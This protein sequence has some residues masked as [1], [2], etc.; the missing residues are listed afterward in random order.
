MLLI[1]PS[2]I[3]AYL[4][5]A[6]LLICKMD[7]GRCSPFALKEL[8]SPSVTSPVNNIKI[9]KHISHSKDYP[10]LPTAFIPLLFISSFI[11]SVR[12]RILLSLMLAYGRHWTGIAYGFF[13]RLLSLIMNTIMCVAGVRF[14]RYRSLKNCLN[15]GL[16][17]VNSLGIFSDET[18]F[19][20]K[21]CGMLACLMMFAIT[22]S[23]CAIFCASL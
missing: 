9:I 20:K 8:N 17:S 18:A 15:F 14:L 3:W 4:W 1:V 5:R 12:S 11:L 13:T 6:S 21:P 16:R 23:C 19:I 22:L 10:F 7:T 2:P